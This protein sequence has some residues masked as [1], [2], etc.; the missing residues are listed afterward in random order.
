VKNVPVIVLTARISADTVKKATES[1]AAK[2][3][4]KASTSPAAL[5]TAVKEI[6]RTHKTQERKMNCWE[7]KKCG[8][9]PYEGPID[10]KKICPVSVD[11]RL[12]GIHGG[13][14][15]GRACW[16]V[17]GSMCDGKLQGSTSQKFGDCFKCSFYKALR[18]EEKEHYSD[19]LYLLDRLRR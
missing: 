15:A 1:G 12:E 11:V 3:L 7:F 6:L 5:A 9:T 4:Q 10:E 2:V 19:T 18:Q 14:N 17:A 16:V 13:K 8:R